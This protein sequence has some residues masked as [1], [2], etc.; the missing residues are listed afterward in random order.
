MHSA[1]LIHR[2]IKPSN[3]LLN[4]DCHA[5]LCDFGLCRSVSETSGPNPV[6]TD[7]VATRWYRAPEILLGSTR[8]TKAVD[9]WAIGCIIGEQISGRPIFPGTSTMNQLDKIIEVC[10]RPTPEDIAA[11][12]SPFAAT[13]LE[14]L[15]PSR[16]RSLTE[17]FPTATAEALDLMRMCLQFNPD[18]R[19]SAEEA[20]RHPYVAQRA[21]PLSPSHG[22]C[23]LAFLLAH[24]LTH[25]L[26]HS[27]T[28]CT[29][30]SLYLL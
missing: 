2:D 28:R 23:F 24:S 1:Q 26:T 19:C 7:Y 15:P 6:L 5:K 29:L 17:I 10:G 22:Y 16:P 20:I 27:S 4:S 21:A 18:K 25:S 9:M 8:Y 12:K 30:T 3:L 13:M 11:I 14:S